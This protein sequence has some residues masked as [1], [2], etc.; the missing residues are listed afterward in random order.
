MSNPVETENT[1]M[2]NPAETAPPEAPRVAVT[3][4]RARRGEAEDLFVGLNGVNYLIPKG[5]RVELPRA[6]AAEIERARAAE[7][8]RHEAAARLQA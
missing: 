8:Y 3:L 1:G 5:R 4:P 2:S 7:D 6:V